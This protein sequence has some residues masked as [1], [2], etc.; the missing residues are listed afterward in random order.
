M[1]IKKYLDDYTDKNKYRLYI[2][3]DGKDTNHTKIFI[4]GKHFSGIQKIN[5]KANGCGCAQCDLTFIPFNLEKYDKPFCKNS[6]I[7]SSFEEEL[8]TA[9]LESG[10]ANTPEDTEVKPAELKELNDWENV[11]EIA[12]NGVNYDTKII[13]NGTDIGLITEF[14]FFQEVQNA[15]VIKCTR[16]IMDPN[17][18]ELPKPIILNFDDMINDV[19]EL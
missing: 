3:T 2:L 18:V 1:S 4:D 11:L 8:E 12:S 10:K 14:D 19:N 15:P 9:L 17:F 5:F 13:L 16:L 7:N 6:E